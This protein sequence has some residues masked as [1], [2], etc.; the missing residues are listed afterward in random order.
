M[1]TQREWE[2]VLAA[3]FFFFAVLFWAVAS[4][5]ALWICRSGGLVAVFCSCVPTS[6]SALKVY[7]FLK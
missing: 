7:S 2:A 1:R 3:F 5:Y 4:I 6:A